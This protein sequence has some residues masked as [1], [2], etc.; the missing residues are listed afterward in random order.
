MKSKTQLLRIEEKQSKK[1]NYFSFFKLKVSAAF[2]V[3]FSPSYAC[4]CACQ[5]TM[6]LLQFNFFEVHFL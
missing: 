5:A 6:P 3:F 1:L 4:H 2:E